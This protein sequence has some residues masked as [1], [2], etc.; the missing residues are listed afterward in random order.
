MRFI[1]PS[2]EFIKSTEPLKSNQFVVLF[3]LPNLLQT[4]PNL[5][6]IQNSISQ[7][8]S[9]DKLPDE[10]I[11]LQDQE[12]SGTQ[13]SQILSLQTIN[14]PTITKSLNVV[15]DSL[16]NGIVNRTITNYTHPDSVDI[17]FREFKNRPIEKIMTEW[18]NLVNNKVKG[19]LGRQKDYKGRI[20]KIEYDPHLL[21]N[22][23]S[24]ESSVWH[25]VLNS[26]QLG[27]N[28]ITRV[29]ILEGVFCES[30]DESP[31]D[32]TTSD[33]HNVPVTFNVDLQFEVENFD[34]LTDE[35]KT[36]IR[37]LYGQV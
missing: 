30:F 37:E 20:I 4:S 23:N 36:H 2:Y 13:L 17:T 11:N 25:S 6:N 8:K 12:Q 35:Y 5:T 10:V 3:D 34:E 21:P 15:T 31:N 7:I 19:T 29:V 16:Y 26:D 18:Q 14:F 22:S 24:T 1:Q 33:Y 9:S 28:P 27:Q 32:R